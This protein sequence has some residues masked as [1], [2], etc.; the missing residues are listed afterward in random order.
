MFAWDRETDQYLAIWAIEGDYAHDASCTA[1]VVILG[2][3][4]ITETTI[5]G[6]YTR[7]DPLSS[8]YF[9]E[10]HGAKYRQYGRWRETQ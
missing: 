2:E 10:D 9:E 1:K 4:E 5:E 8:Q 3:E 7:I 6:W